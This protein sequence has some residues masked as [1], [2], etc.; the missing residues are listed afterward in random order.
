MK[1]TGTIS[2]GLTFIMLLLFSGCDKV[3]NLLDVTFTSDSTSVDF[4][5]DSSAAGAFTSTQVVVQS[6]LNQQITDN[7]GSIS[8][9]K[10][11]EIQGCK[12]VVLSADRNLNAFQSLE[13]YAEVTGQAEKKLAWIDNV[14]ENVTSVE[15]SLSSDDI[16]SLIDQDQYTITV[17]GVL[18]NALAPSIN[19]RAI[20]RYKVVV[21]PK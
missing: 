18:D 5:V 11:V 7:G 6:D 9:L 17:K 14:P 8:E 15:L 1:K 3:K 10:S 4:R 16:K 21:G 12:I 13:V 2:L 19:L 20:V